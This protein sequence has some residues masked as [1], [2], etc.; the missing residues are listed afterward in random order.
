ML[1]KKQAEEIIRALS[2][3]PADKVAEAQDF[4]LFLRARY[5]Q[6][7]AID[8]SDAWT[9]EDLRDL[10]AASLAHLNQSVIE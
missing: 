5:G 2:T 1:D 7:Q 8:E 6:Q 9:E 10:T 4:I 3:L